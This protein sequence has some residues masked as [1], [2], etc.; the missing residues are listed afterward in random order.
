MRPTLA[1]NQVT[2]Q[3]TRSNACTSTS[4]EPLL[5]QSWGNPRNGFR[6]PIYPYGC[7]S[8]A[9]SIPDREAGGKALFPVDSATFFDRL[10]ENLQRG[11][12]PT[13]FQ[14]F[15]RK[16]VLLWPEVITPPS[17]T[18]SWRVRVQTHVLEIVSRRWRGEVRS[19][20]FWG[21][22]SDE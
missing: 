20:C 12:P 15:R 5:Q 9:S 13:P 1:P 16:C 2:R 8:N 7:S 18:N 14:A 17:R 19:W 22:E 4:L 10:K 3:A 6:G 21:P 11:S